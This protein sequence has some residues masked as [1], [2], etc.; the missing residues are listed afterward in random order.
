[1][2]SS[3]VIKIDL[4]DAARRAI[5]EY[6]RSTRGANQLSSDARMVE[7]S[8]TCVQV[9]SGDGRCFELTIKERM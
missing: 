9:F 7:I 8:P 4:L 1:M 3:R 2:T 5:A 6:L